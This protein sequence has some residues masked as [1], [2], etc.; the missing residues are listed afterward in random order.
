MKLFKK[1]N[2]AGGITIPQQF[3]H[4]LNIPKGAAVEMEE[5]DGMLIIKKHITTCLVC[6]N[7]DNVTVINGVEVC[8]DCAKR[9]AGGT[10]NGNDN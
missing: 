7:A 1:V 3:R 5:T 6:G 10:D 9:F 8:A 4:A 2:K